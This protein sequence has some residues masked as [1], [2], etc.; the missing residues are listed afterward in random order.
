VTD[1]IVRLHGVEKRY[2]TEPPVVAV[3]GVDLDVRQ[4]ERIA[5]VGPS[6]SG[7]STLLQLMGTLER[8]TRGRVTV[9]GHDVSAL[10]SR[11]IA[12]LRARYIG[13]VFQHFF[14]LD[15]RSALDNVGDGLLYRGVAR[16]ERRRAA[17]ATLDRVGLG[18][19]MQHRPQQLS[20][21]E[22]QRVALARA[23]VGR[24]A[25]VFADEPTGNLDSVSGTRIIEL[26][27][28]LNDDGTTVVLITHDHSMASS[29][30]RRVTMHDG[31]IVD[32]TSR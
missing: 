25:V 5:I 17:A 24:P 22:R 26:L 14:L 32:T 31:R 21:G 23:I 3:D 2:G 4:G 29:M 28:E 15:H 11:S 19:R 16:T 12:A 10:S 13:F 20:G 7:K 6:G 30:D 27:R 8:P 18:H 1:T 9:A